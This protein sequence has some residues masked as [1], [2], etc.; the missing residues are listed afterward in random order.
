MLKI[1]LRKIMM[2]HLYMIDHKIFNTV[3]RSDVYL[4]A[5]QFFCLNYNNDSCEDFY[6]YK[7]HCCI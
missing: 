7:S 1:G 5:Q 3:G 4:A 2:Y 6:F